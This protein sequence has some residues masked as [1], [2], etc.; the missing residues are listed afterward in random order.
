MSTEPTSIKV[1][2]I[3]GG[4]GLSTLLKGLKHFH[5]RGAYHAPDSRR[6]IFISGLTAIVTGT[7]DGGSSGRLGKDFNILPPGAIRNC[8][9]A[10]SDD[11]E[12]LS[13]LFQY[14]FKA[15]AG[16]E[17]TKFATHIGAVLNEL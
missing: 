5:R 1:V 8:L 11:A 3:G 6:E 4:T 17:T 2:A 16:H 15:R 12:L 10:L 7:D 9:V 14:R 13:Q